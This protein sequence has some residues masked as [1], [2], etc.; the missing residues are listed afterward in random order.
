MS[1][2]GGPPVHPYQPEGIWEDVAMKQSTTLYYHA[3][4]GEN[5]YRRSLYTVWKRTAP[6]PS[7]EI[8]NAPS[9]EA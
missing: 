5:L 3:D 1:R 9:R 7:M 6:P 2:L 4:E 8:L